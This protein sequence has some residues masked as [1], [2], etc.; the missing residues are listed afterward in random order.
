MVDADGRT[1]TYVTPAIAYK[2]VPTPKTA[3]ARLVEKAPLQC[4]WC[5]CKLAADFDA[6]TPVF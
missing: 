1:L 3:L 6:L 5:K 2:V 4:S